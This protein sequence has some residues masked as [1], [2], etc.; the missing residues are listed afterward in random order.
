MKNLK[1]AKELLEKSVQNI[2]EL[3]NNM[4]E[5]NGKKYILVA[6]CDGMEFK[7]YR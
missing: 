4:K 1:E 7:D 5:K 2:I 6:E 3:G